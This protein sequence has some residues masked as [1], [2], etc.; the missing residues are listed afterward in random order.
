MYAKDEKLEFSNTK[1]TRYIW[2]KVESFRTYIIHFLTKY[3]FENYYLFE[4]FH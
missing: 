4:N 2:C 3:I 1:V